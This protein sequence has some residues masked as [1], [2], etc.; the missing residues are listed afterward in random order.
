MAKEQG[1]P[2]NPSRISGVCGRIKCCMAYEYN[3]YKEFWKKLP[4][5]GDKIDTADGSGKK[6]NKPDQ[7]DSEKE[8]RKS[9]AKALGLHDGTG[10][11]RKGLEL[12]D[13]GSVRFCRDCKHYLRHPFVSRCLLTGRDVEPMGDCPSFTPRPVDGGDVEGDTN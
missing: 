4:R 12:F 11:S 6:N 10:A 8:G 3:V 5:L 1:L 13:D 2:L 9:V 7:E